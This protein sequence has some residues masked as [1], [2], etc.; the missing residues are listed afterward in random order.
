M[1]GVRGD[2]SG[3]CGEERG[4]ETDL[5][6]QRL[7]N[8]TLEQLR[9][10]VLVQLVLIVLVIVICSRK[11]GLEVALEFGQGADRERQTLFRSAI[12]NGTR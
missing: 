9:P 1:A 2:K 12:K 7:A 10:P 4:R 3:Q 6:H 11:L 5:S 8:A